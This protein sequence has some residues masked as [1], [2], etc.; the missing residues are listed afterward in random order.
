MRIL[1]AGAAGFIGSHIAARLA[2]EGHEI[3]AGA[4]DLAW[5]RV[6]FPRYRWVEADFRKRVNWADH[7]AGVDAVINCVGVL[8][9]GGADSTRAAHV[10]GARALF[11][12]C[13]AAGV[14]RVIQISAVG[15][16]AAAGTAYARTKEEGDQSLM[17]RDLDWVIVKPSLVVARGVYGGTA[18][19][20][21]LAGLPFVTPLL[22]TSGQ[23]RPI[24]MRDLCEAVSRLLRLNAPRRVVIDAAGPL[25]QSLPELI[26][27]HR[28]WLGFGSARQWTAPH[29]LTDI[30]FTVGDML[31]AI[32][33]R[34]SLRSTSRA[35]M[36]HDV[37]GDPDSLKRELSLDVRAG[38][39]ALA[40]EPA[41]VQDRWHAR[42]YFVKPAARLA[43]ATF[44]ILTGIVCLTSG[45]AE[46]MALARAA[47]LGGLD[48]LAADGGGLFD[49]AI[50]AAFLVLA[51]WRRPLLAIMAAVTLAYICVLTITL[52]HLWSDPLGRLMKLIPFFALLAFVAAVE[53][54]R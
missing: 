19:V 50:G 43:L 24:H 48:A 26:A 22:A 25:A 40:D 46:A 15:A 20:R 39:A 14:R 31:G 54:E 32:G 13:E 17:A 8:Q 1:I 29:L 16:E 51:R 42:L 12:A 4:R 6:R 36:A 28:A 3:V 23:F 7:L 49:I 47:G 52:P 45:R 41:S 5:A 30:A 34:T 27:A 33:V 44:W 9:D 53:N 21:G 18:L 11:D 38:M 35:Q 10:D 37:G 2:G